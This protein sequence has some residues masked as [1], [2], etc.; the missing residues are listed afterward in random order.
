MTTTTVGDRI[1]IWDLP[2]RVFHWGLAIAIAGAFLTGEEDAPL[3]AWHHVLGW[4]AA[5][6]IAFRVI[7]GFIGG[8]HARFAAFLRPSRLGHHLSD[9]LAR[10]PAK[11]VGHNPLGGLAIL[12]LLALTL[13]AVATGVQ[14]GED[15]H[16]AVVWPLLVL[17]AV[18][19][20]AVVAMSLLGRENLVRAMVT[21]S[22]ASA[23]HPGAIDARRAPV[24]ALPLALAV[25]VGAAWGA[26]LVDPKAYSPASPD[27]GDE[28][29]ER[30]EF[31]PDPDLSSSGEERG[32]DGDD[33]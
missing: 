16:E 32:R 19:V 10:R 28:R 2:V 13:A 12:A 33:D 18:H 17:I 30:A 23:A 6:L 22:K 7:W 20:A 8:E 5:V 24:W 3:A 31:R 27:A 14:G 9:L 11:T 26:L 15:L 1:R 25:T 21:G 29:G 4:T